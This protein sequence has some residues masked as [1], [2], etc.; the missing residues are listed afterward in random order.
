MIA[1]LA[2]L[3][4][5]GAIGGAILSG[6]SPAATPT[7]SPTATLAPTATPAPTATSAPTATPA[8]APESWAR[9]YVERGPYQVGSRALY[10]HD[11]D[12]PF[13]GWNARHAS[14][15]YKAMLAEVNAAGERQIVAAHVWHPVEAGATGRAATVDDFG[16]SRSAVFRNAY[17]Q[18]ALGFLGGLVSEDGTP[19]SFTD[20]AALAAISAEAGKRVVN[21]LHQAPIAAGR[22]PIIIAAHG[23]GGNSLMWAGFAEY[24]ASRGYVVVAPSFISDSA[25]PNALDSPDSRYA[26]SADPA[27][28]DRAYQTI[29]GEFKVIPGFYKYFFGYEGSIGFDGAP[30]AG[31]LE[32]IPGGGEHVGEMMGELFTQRVDDV[33]TII[34]GLISLDKGGDACAAEYAERGQPVH[35]AD[36]C[37]L[38][39]G[40]L[41]VDRIGI[42]GHS[43]GS[44]TA[45]FS[46][47]RIDRVVAAAG[48]NNG[49]PRYWEPPGVFGDG[50]AADGQPAGS[51]KPALQIHG[52]EDAFVQG[53]FRGLMWNAL[54]AAGGDP[55]EIWVLEQERV[56][57]TDENPQPIARNAYNRATGDKAI[58]SVKDVNHGS[59]VDDFAAVFSERNP[60]AAGGERYWIASRP[61]P[62]KAVGQDALD[63]TF[64]GE[65]YTPLGWGSVDGYEVYL[66]SFIRNY[67]TRNWFDYYLKGDEAGLRFT[68]N[69][70]AE[71]GVLDVRVEL[72]GT[73][74]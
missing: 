23:L 34:D 66:P 31:R 54:S 69:P 24:L 7:P 13:D 39:G 15:G 11:P 57:P 17:G 27:D 36:V 53:V 19:P 45:Q 33:E 47:A 67:Y 50:T 38:F 8:P 55:E 70:I 40:A 32:A 44:M 12:R 1:K 22:F 68:E 14:D 3:V 62:R 16:Q 74:R 49:P 25:L 58:I 71:Q 46:V 51:P 64:Q 21:S 5:A 73:R 63:P 65:P 56:L 52:S 28:V 41:D 72:A 48:Y 29:L 60:I 9:E 18:G 10:F 42:L 35:G 26:A 61:A 6:C 59:L 43:L 4:L 20:R 37:G 2:P 30:G